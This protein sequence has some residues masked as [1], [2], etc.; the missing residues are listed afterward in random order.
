MTLRILYCS[1]TPSP[2]SMQARIKPS[3][4]SSPNTHTC[5]SSAD[6]NRG[7]ERNP[8]SDNRQPGNSPPVPVPALVVAALN[9]NANA[10]IE[11]EVLDICSPPVPRNYAPHPTPPPR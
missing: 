1:V 5:A 7:G 2:L 4:L 6:P 3:P 10:Q 11:M 9:A 8:S